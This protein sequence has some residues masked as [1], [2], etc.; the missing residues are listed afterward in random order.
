[1][2]VKKVMICMLVIAMLSVS[3]G[4]VN[5]QNGPEG[6][7]PGDRFGQQERPLARGLINIVGLVSDEIGV[8]MR[9]LTQALR[10]GATLAEVITNNGGDVDAVTAAVIDEAIL[11]I[12]AA[13]DEGRI[14]PEV[15]EQ[16]LANV[17]D[18]VN[19][20]MTGELQGLFQNRAGDNVR[21]RLLATAIG[22]VVD[23][24]GLDRQAIAQQV[25]DGATL[26]EL[27]TANGGDVDAVIAASLAT[28]TER[29]NTAV[30]EG[31][32]DEDRAAT[33]LENAQTALTE[34]MN[35]DL[36]DRLDDRG[37]GRDRMLQTVTRT[38]RQ[39]VSEATGLNQREI[40][41]ALRDGA[42]LES[43][44]TDNGVDVAAFTAE[45]T[46]EFEARINEAV[47]NGVLNEDRAATLI[48]GFGTRLQN[49]LTR[50]RI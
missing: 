47:A 10:A 25:R 1:M 7:R 43:V 13:L 14:P 30:A 21:D 20:A 17:E 33:L 11:S 27:V 38:V 22:A 26:G 2:N 31:N 24:T 18:N 48:D 8:E 34:L 44:L 46:T 45:I 6:D 29:V 9:H 5:A 36:R 3:V 49:L 41:Q 42:T 12:E 28:I 15:A 4:A 32:M 50:S 39:Q 37:P 35:G 16:M 23:A 40:Q 19:A